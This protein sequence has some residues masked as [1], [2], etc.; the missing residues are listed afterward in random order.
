MQNNNVEMPKVSNG[1]TE[2][3][4]DLFI[5]QSYS[6]TPG[7]CIAHM[8]YQLSF[9]ELFVDGGLKH[10]GKASGH[11]LQWTKALIQKPAPYWEGTAAYKGHMKEIKLTD[12]RK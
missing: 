10:E 1:Y 7:F 3:F 6:S 11:S 4:F 2:I 12:Y 8:T 5:R 9:S